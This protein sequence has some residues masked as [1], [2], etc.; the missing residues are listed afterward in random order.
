MKSQ[1]EKIRRTY[2]HID[3]YTAKKAHLKYVKINNLG[4]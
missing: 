3:D 1:N 4:L 2:Y